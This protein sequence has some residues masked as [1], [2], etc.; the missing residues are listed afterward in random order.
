MEKI[1][2]G[3]FIYVNKPCVVLSLL[4][5]L[6]GQ[7]GISTTTTTTNPT[8]SGQTVQ[9]AQLATSAGAALSAIPILQAQPVSSSSLT[10]LQS[11]LQ[12]ISPASPQ[13]ANTIVETVTVVNALPINVTQ[14][15]TP[16]ATKPINVV[17]ATTAGSQLQLQ[18]NANVQKQTKTL[19]QSENCTP[20]KQQ[21]DV[22]RPQ[23][24]SGQRGNLTNS[25]SNNI[26]ISNNNISQT[27]TAAQLANNSSIKRPS[28]YQI[29]PAKVI[30]F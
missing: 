6:N 11:H 15:S 8:S 17:V 16:A 18:T 12:P 29:N 30:F 23:T 19:A 2:T 5:D 9:M 13:K 3:Q 22:T 4:K 26:N 28:S 21:P 25:T 7:F 10:Q 1:E 27:T 24:P 14:P 20:V